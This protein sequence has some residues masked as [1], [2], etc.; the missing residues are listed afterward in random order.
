MKPNTMYE[1]KK[2]K[3]KRVEDAIYNIPYDAPLDNYTDE[4][5]ELYE[6]MKELTGKDNILFRDAIDEQREKN[7]NRKVTSDTV[8][9]SE[10]WKEWL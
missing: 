3:V 10:S 5:V 6:A 4:L 8:N 9:E 2:T 7:T 1:I